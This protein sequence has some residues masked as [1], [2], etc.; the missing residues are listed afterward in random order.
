[1]FNLDSTKVKSIYIEIAKKMLFFNRRMGGLLKT[2]IRLL[3]ANYLYCGLEVKSAITM[4]SLV[5][6]KIKHNSY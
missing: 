6:P 3:C 4:I 1:M 2:N 5:S